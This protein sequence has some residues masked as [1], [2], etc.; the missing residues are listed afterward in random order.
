MEMLGITLANNGYKVFIPRIP[1]LKI[2]DIS[3]V[4]IKWFVYFYKWLIDDDDGGGGDDDGG[5]DCDDDDD[6]EDDNAQ[7]QSP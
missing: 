4:N 5:D 7:T 2:L 6:D 3:E 1:P